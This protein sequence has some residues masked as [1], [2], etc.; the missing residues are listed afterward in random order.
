M[1]SSM[2][3]NIKEDHTCYLKERFLVLRKLQTAKKLEK[4]DMI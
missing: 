1:F 4:E 3:V 2:H